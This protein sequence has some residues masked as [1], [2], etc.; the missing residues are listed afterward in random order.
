MPAANTQRR[1][2]GDLGVFSWYQFF[3]LRF[4]Q[5]YL[6][7]LIFKLKIILCWADFWGL[8]VLGFFNIVSS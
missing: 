7:G 4:V 2:V 5:D 6:L 8:W 1:D 3:I